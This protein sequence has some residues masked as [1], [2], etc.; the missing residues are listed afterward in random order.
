MI[1]LADNQ[2]F[3][4]NSTIFF[5]DKFKRVSLRCSMNRNNCCLMISTVTTKI[6]VKNDTGRYQQSFLCDKLVEHIVLQKNFFVYEK[7]KGEG[8]K[9]IPTGVFLYRMK[10]DK[11]NCS[12]VMFQIS[13]D[14]YP[15]PCY[16]FVG[17]RQW[18]WKKQIK[19]NQNF[20]DGK[21]LI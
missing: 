2:M 14:I 8:E 6:E 18:A 17:L 16:L 15:T 11:M 10:A 4:S 1:Y 19:R 3:K 13:N 7:K 20:E 5:I 21:W 9:D 12:S